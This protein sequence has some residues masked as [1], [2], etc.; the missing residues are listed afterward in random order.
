M[1]FTVS[2]KDRILIV[3]QVEEQDPEEPVNTLPELPIIPP[4]HRLVSSGTACSLSQRTQILYPFQQEDKQLTENWW[5]SIMFLSAA[6]LHIDQIKSNALCCELQNQQHHMYWHVF[7]KL[8]RKETCRYCVRTA[9]H[10][11]V[12]KLVC[13]KLLHVVKLHPWER[14]LS[15]A[16]HCS[17]SWGTG[18]Q[19]MSKLQSRRCHVLRLRTVWKSALY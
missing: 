12:C 1:L 7:R 19:F 17:P 6:F 15:S 10:Y 4:L 5:F 3:M 14:S 13:S 11:I 2:C 9:T 8:W 16:H 18:G